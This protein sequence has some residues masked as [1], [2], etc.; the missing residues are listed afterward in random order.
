MTAQ[1][2]FRDTVNRYLPVW[3]SE[4]PGGFLGKTVGYRVVWTI[5]ALFDELAE[6]AI[7]ALQAPWP[8]QGTP[9]A[10]PYIGR[11]RAM[12]RAQGESEADYTARLVTWL[13]RARQWGS[14]IAIAR[15]VHEYLANRPRVRIYNRAGQCV[16]V[17]QTTGAISHFAPGTTA[18]NWD[19]V[20]FPERAKRRGDVWICV[21]P[22]PWARSPNIGS[23]RVIGSGDHGIGHDVTRVEIDAVK[24]EIRQYKSAH[25]NVVAVIWTTDAT[26]FDPTV[27]ASQPAGDWGQWSTRGD[28]S[29]VASGRGNSPTCRFW[30]L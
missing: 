19:G 25:T 10:F 3:L 29:R 17:A 20:D 18:W 1:T 27:P 13:D 8:S 6:T 16:E 7:E 2:R 11:S 26:L 4:R 28:G 5:A 15:S 22:D 9:D 24:S 12:I 21:Y 30:E 23:H 14:M